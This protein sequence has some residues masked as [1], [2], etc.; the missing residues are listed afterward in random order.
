MEKRTLF[1]RREVLRAGGLAGF[2]AVAGLVLHSAPARAGDTAALKPVRLVNPEGN[3]TLVEQAML[4]SGGYFTELGVRPT[5][6]NVSDGAK[7]LAA[8]ISGTGDLCPG[9]GFSGIF[10]A[11]ERGAKVKILAGAAI[12]IPLTLFSKRPEIKSVADLVGRTVGVGAPGALLH[13]LTVALLQRKG[14]DYHKVRFVNVGSS[15]AAFKA[16]AAGV[17]DAGPGDVAYYDLA[18]KYGV[19]A[20]TDG[21]FWKEL[22][23]Y[24][25]QAMYA[26]DQAIAEKRDTLVRVM[27]AYAK[28]FR[29][30]SSPQS[31]AAM[32]AA[33][34]SALGDSVRPAAVAV[35]WRFFQHPGRLATNLVLSDKRI[36]YM[37]KLNV[38]LGLQ[39]T[40][41]PISEV[42]DM[43]LALDAVKLLTS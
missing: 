21:A 33:S 37:Q 32:L 19:H 12:S 43:S 23:L 16:V 3:L 25:G 18:V 8:L 34:R 26:P 11:I 17:V 39:K 42:A 38:E 31:K 30:M 40:I 13:Q 41:L 29:F 1:A 6:L 14:I 7:I 9:S 36:D 28:L 4:N 20:L 35:Q 5:I 15:A 27:A 10:P 24:T 22:P 2:G